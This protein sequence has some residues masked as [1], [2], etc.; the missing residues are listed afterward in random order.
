M[1]TLTLAGSAGGDIQWQQSTNNFATFTNVGTNSATY[2]PNT[3]LTS[4]MYYRA[5][6]SCGSSLT[7]NIVSVGYN[8]PIVTSAPGKTRCGPGKVTLTSTGNAGVTGLNWYSAAS[9]GS[10]ITFTTQSFNSTTRTSS[11]DTVLAANTTFYTSAVSG[12]GTITGIGLPI[13]GVPSTTGASAERGI[14]FTAT[15]SFTLV[16]AQYYSPTT[17]VTNTVTVK[18]YDNTTGAV[19]QTATLPINQAA[20]GWFTMNINFP[21]TAGTYRLTA[22]FTQSVNRDATAQTYPISMGGAGSIAS[23]GGVRTV[24]LTA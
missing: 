2:T 21:I 8:N 13:T 24:T 20:A 3:N 7:S 5:V 11:V 9:G 19:L 6:V 16:S 18:L 15:T 12:L 14:V 22:A 4:T 23:A 10:P 17:A 1:P